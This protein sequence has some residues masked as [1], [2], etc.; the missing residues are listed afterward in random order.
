MGACTPPPVLYAIV[1]TCLYTF[2]GIFYHERAQDFSTTEW[3]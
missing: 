1:E 2:S 3:Q